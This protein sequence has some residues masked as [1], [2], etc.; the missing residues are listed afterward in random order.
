MAEGMMARLLRKALS[1]LVNLTPNVI[2]YSSVWAVRINGKLEQISR[3]KASPSGLSTAAVAMA[4]A[5]HD[6]LPN[7]GDEAEMTLTG[8]SSGEKVL[9]D[10]T[11]TL[12]RAA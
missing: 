1:R 11:V 4:C 9:G 6:N 8:V 3:E 12:R 10:F 2:Y 5:M 7:L